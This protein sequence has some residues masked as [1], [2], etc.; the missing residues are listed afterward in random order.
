MSEIL[1]VL[2]VAGPLL[3]LLLRGHGGGGGLSP[4]NFSALKGYM[5][6]MVL[7]S[8]DTASYCL[9][10]GV[11]QYPYPEVISQLRSGLLN[12]GFLMVGVFFA[13]SA[14]GCCKQLATRENYLDGFLVKKVA[15]VYFPFV[16]I[17]TTLGLLQAVI[18]R[19]FS[20]M[21]LIQL[22]ANCFDF[23][24]WPVHWYIPYAMLFYIAFFCV[25]STCKKHAALV[26]TA[27][28]LIYLIYNFVLVKSELYYVSQVG[29]IVG[30]LFATYEPA[31]QQFLGKKKAL[32]TAGVFLFFM[33]V[34][35]YP[36]LLWTRGYYIVL[37]DNGP[38]YRMLS[39]ALFSVF[40]FLFIQMVDF[41][42]SRYLTFLGSISLEIYLVHSFVVAQTDRLIHFLQDTQFSR[43]T[44]YALKNLLT[45]IL[46]ILLS[47][48]FHALLSHFHS[49]M[50]LHTKQK[51]RLC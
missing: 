37:L 18:F 51:Q 29:I 45:L 9:I 31:I 38:I 10:D 22:F 15:T 34:Y 44:I 17:G 46:T 6:F 40:M 21:T 13:L 20:G 35:H 1:L 30:V 16:F 26:L 8:H 14:Y 27:G 50:G 33:F 32:W 4:Q 48:A 12:N 41:S 7:Y 2:L 47:L 24:V 28:I 11:Y 25:Y 19:S 36:F 42:R 39:V 23:S 3:V 5:A 43:S 49:K